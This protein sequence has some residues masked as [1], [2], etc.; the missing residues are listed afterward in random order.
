MWILGLDY[1]NIFIYV[2][3]NSLC[4]ILE[5]YGHISELINGGRKLRTSL[6]ILLKYILM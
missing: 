5:N 3:L 6:E 2:G 1:S 4:T